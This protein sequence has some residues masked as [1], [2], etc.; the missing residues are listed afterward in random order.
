MA[1]FEQHKQLA[2]RH[3]ESTDQQNSHQNMQNTDFDCCY[4]YLII[5]A[6]LYGSCFARIATDQGKRVLVVERRQH[7]GGNCYTEEEDGI[8]IHR[9]GPHIFHTSNEVV[10]EFV[11]RYCTFNNFINTPLAISKNELFSLP[12]NMLTFHQLWG[13]TTPS[14]AEEKLNQQRLQLDR[15]AQNLE[16]QALTLVGNDLYERLIRGYTRKQWKRDPKELPPEIIKRIPIRLTY[17]NNYF[18]DRHQGIPHGGYTALF[19][20]LLKNIDVRLGV[21]FHEDRE[22]W[23]SQANKIVYTGQID[24]LFNYDLGELEYRT[25]KFEDTWHRTS[26]YQGNAVINYCDE[27]IPHTRLIEHKHFNP[28]IV[29][30]NQTVVTSETPV[31][32]KRGQ[33]PYYPINNKTNNALYE[34]YAERARKIPNLILGGRLAEYQY[35]DMHAVVASAIR[36]CQAIGMQAEN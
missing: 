14:E 15:P 11:N 6:G 10:W 28:E 8:H 4:D 32:W 18:N 16:E 7:I 25:L 29:E 27:H 19:N 24:Q 30:T 1:I 36:R 5:G 23:L 20:T 35:M 22:Y 17:N 9:Y 21:D 31:A 12:F 33:T 34:I 2:K 3:K 26:N 13:V